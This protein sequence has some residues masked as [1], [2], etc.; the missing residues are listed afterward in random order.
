MQ[1]SSANARVPVEASGGLAG[2]SV[3]Q[4]GIDVG[5]GCNR[6]CT[7]WLALLNENWLHPLQT[8]V[9]NLCGVPD[10]SGVPIAAVQN[11]CK[12]VA[13]SLGSAHFAHDWQG[14]TQ[15]RTAP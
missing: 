9:I 5:F 7:G 8:N 3:L 11:R 1:D 10:M 15:G 12:L 6:D 4:Q 13:L 14:C 2:D